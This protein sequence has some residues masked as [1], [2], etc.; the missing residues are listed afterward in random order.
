MIYTC[1]VF[2]PGCLFYHSAIFDTVPSTIVS[3]VECSYPIP[4]DAS[5]GFLYIGANTLAIPM[6]FLGQVLLATDSSQP[7]PFYP[8][9]IW[10]ICALALAMVPV[11]TF[12]GQYFRL[13]ED[14]N[15][16]TVDG[17]KSVGG[18]IR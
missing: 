12:K 7:A 1:I 8:Y 6:T 17:D 13:Q 5:V 2:T 10:V 18:D 16:N 3:T 4:E 15:R 14:T 11:S 9:G